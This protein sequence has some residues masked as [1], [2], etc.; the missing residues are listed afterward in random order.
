[1]LGG[2]TYL[3]QNKILGGAYFKFTSKPKATATIADRGFCALALDLDWGAEN[4]IIEI[5]SLDFARDTMSVFGVSYT[6]DRMKYLRELSLHCK[7]MYIYRLNGNGTKASCALATAKYSGLR[8]NDIKIVV[9]ANIDDESNFDVST[10]VGNTL[11]DTQ[12]VKNASTLVDNDFV[13]FNKTVTLEATAG[14]NLTGGENGT[15]DDASHQAFLDKLESYPSVNA[16]GYMGDNDTIKG[17]Y[18]SYVKRLRDEIG[19]RLQ[20]VV[21]NKRADSEAVVNVKNSADL[22]PWVLGVIGGTAVNKS[23][24]NMTYDGELDV[25]TDFTQKALE[26]CLKNGEF[27]LHKVG[28]TVKILEDINSFTSITDEKGDIFKDNQTIRVIDT[29]A[30]SVA[31]IFAS[32]YLGKVPNDASGRVSLWSDIVAIHKQ[33]NDIRALEDFD[34]KLITV[35]Q[36]DTKKSVLVKSNCTVVNTMVRLYMDTVIE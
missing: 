36:G 17:L 21:F 7:T 26:N 19:I 24:T 15:S 2:G 14:V 30:D 31:E 29:I 11:V 25:N 12:I 32:K 16:V 28:D 5:D 1:M 35:E 33:L 13:I 20:A 4:Q 18:V 34:S 6:D 3:V 22:V 23:A 8:G 27:V 9:Q 10:Y